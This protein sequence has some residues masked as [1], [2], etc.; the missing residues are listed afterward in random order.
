MKGTGRRLPKVLAFGQS[1]LAALIA[2]YASLRDKKRIECTFLALTAEEL[3][4]SLAVGRLDDRIPTAIEAEDPDAVMLAIAGNEHNILGIVNHPRRFDLVLPE[5]PD[6][7]LDEQAE[8]LPV[9]LVAASFRTHL[10]NFAF[11]LLRHIRS[12]VSAPLYALEAPPPIA[13]G[14]YIASQVEAKMRKQENRGASPSVLQKK[15]QFFDALQERGVG[16]PLLRYKL[17]RVQSSLLKELCT[18]LGI[19]FVP[20]P[21]GA[22]D[23]EGLLSEPY[24]GG[25][26]TH[27]NAAYGQLVLDD[28]ASKIASA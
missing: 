14:E 11:P 9:G 7:M 28:I 5:A 16:R 18:V 20:A 3:K 19:K 4:P 15:M 12:A 24:W 13:S 23:A 6:L 25:D 8:I 10:E 21:V 17:W 26:A 22:Q 27:A 1:H 2:G